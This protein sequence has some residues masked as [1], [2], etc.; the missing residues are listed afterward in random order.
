MKNYTCEEDASNKILKESKF[1][2]SIYS[3][4]LVNGVPVWQLEKRGRREE[5]AQTFRD[6]VERKGKENSKL[7]AAAEANMARN[8]LTQDRENG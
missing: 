5:E 2:N 6:E 1:N 4:F 8:G 3:D 7:A